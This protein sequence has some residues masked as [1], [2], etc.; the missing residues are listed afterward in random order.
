MKT[1][2]FVFVCFDSGVSA[3][4]PF[5]RISQSIMSQMSSLGTLPTLPTIPNFMT[6]GGSVRLRDQSSVLGA[7]TSTK[8]R[9]K[10]NTGFYY[11]IREDVFF[12]PFTPKEEIQ[13]N[14]PSESSAKSS[15]SRP[16]KSLRKLR[17]EDP[18]KSPALLAD[19][20]GE[21]LMELR[22][23]REDIAALRDEMRSMKKEMMSSSLDYDSQSEEKRSAEYTDELAHHPQGLS[24]FVARKRRQKEF[25]NIGTDIEQWAKKL[26]FEE[27]GEVNDWKE[28]QCSK[29]FKNKFNKR[30]NIKCYLK[31][32]R[33]SSV[34]FSFFSIQLLLTCIFV[35][36]CT[37]FIYWV[38]VT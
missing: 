6:R 10:N 26:L 7:L 13:N 22:E 20:M 12:T 33:L 37:T 17:D 23:M 29:L 21:T 27:Q 34:T 28:V 11:G 5:S 15:V 8:R 32:R 31:V 1:W 38:V 4:N 24:G 18:S 3:S 2:I 14:D 19:V 9:R 36:T 16:R 30:G 35:T 25:D